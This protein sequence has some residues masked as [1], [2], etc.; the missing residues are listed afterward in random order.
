M[1]PSENL[2]GERMKVKDSEG[3]PCQGTLKDSQKTCGLFRQPQKAGLYLAT[4]FVPH[5]CLNQRCSEY[6]IP[7]TKEGVRQQWGDLKDRVQLKG[8]CR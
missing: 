6:G 4:Q 2:G 5:L 7:Y 1:A 3:V 8:D